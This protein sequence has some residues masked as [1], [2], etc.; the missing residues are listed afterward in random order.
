MDTQ[1]EVIDESGDLMII[2]RS[3]TQPLSWS[4]DEDYDA[5]Q[6]T[7]EDTDEDTDEDTIED[8]EDDE[9][10]AEMIEELE[11]LRI[12]QQ[13]PVRVADTDI[14]P[15]TLL[16]QDS[17]STEQPAGDVDNQNLSG[18]DDDLEPKRKFLV[19][20]H[21][22]RLASEVFRKDLDPNGPWRQ[23]EIQSDGLREKYLES[24]NPEALKHVLNVI[25]VRNDQV[26]DKLETEELAEVAVIVDYFQCHEA[27]RFAVK[28][29][30]GKKQ[31]EEVVNDAKPGRPLVLWLLIASVF[32]IDAII[33]AAAK[34]IIEHN[35]GP[36]ES[37]GLPIAE[38]ITS[39]MNSAQEAVTK[40]FIGNIYQLRDDLS[41]C[42]I[43]SSR[44]V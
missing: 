9:I 37:M 39:R 3:R 7:N 13:I 34:I 26:P 43:S 22:L 33:K 6:D 30:I 23:P 42:D 44:S 10:I 15:P 28:S 21:V 41:A 19:S 38:N 2:L 40:A 35:E 20:S 16:E 5:N 17:K 29:W 24:F 25:H 11:G 4:H 31:I 27:M 8:V 36:F 32:G 14:E 18:D 1:Y 12:E